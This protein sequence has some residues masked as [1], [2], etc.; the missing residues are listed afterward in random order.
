MDIYKSIAWEMG[1]PVERN[2]AALYR[3]IR[4]EATR[5]AIESKIRPAL[6]VD[7]C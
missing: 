3:V 2:R 4:A 6:I 1:L 7:S 5:L